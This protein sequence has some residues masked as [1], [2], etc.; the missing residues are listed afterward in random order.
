MRSEDRA[1]Y[2]EAVWDEFRRLHQPGRLTMSSMEFQL[3]SRWMDKNIP[4]SVVL[5]GLD[6]TGGKPR[7]IMACENAVERAY[8]YWFQAMGGL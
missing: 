5:R 1:T 2:A 7:T 6:E 8:G 3:V 4:L